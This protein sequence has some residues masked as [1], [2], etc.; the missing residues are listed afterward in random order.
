[1]QCALWLR[2]PVPRE[3]RNLLY[4]GFNR[5]YERIEAGY[6]RLVAFI[7]R[8]SAAMA[9]IALVLAGLSVWGVLR[10]PTAF[11]PQEDA[12]YLMVAVQLPDG[13]SLERTEQALARV[14]DAADA[15]SGV[16]HVIEISGLSLL[17]GAPLSS[18]GAVWVVLKDWSQR[19]PAEHL[20]AIRAKLSQ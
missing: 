10:L 9:A 11:I 5:V 13:A 15:L 12:G 16:E 20:A 18:A 17:G 2:T 6:L 1:T 3:Q 7:T 4:R 14:R 8:R 19:G